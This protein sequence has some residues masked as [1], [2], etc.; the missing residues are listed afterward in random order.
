M[1][2]AGCDFVL[3]EG[4]FIARIVA[5]GHNRDDVRQGLNQ[6]RK[7]IELTIVKKQDPEEPHG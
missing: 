3:A 4:A 2:H 5:L 6:G 7:T 1:E